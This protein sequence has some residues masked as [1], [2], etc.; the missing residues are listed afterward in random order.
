MEL[1][2]TFI[3]FILALFFVLLSLIHLND[4]YN[5]YSISKS[6]LL[7]KVLFFKLLFFINS[8]RRIYERQQNC[9]C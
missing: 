1:T 3:N 4:G 7:P 6:I 8:A 2:I 5:R 9:L